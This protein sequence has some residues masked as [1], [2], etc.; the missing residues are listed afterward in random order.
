MLGVMWKIELNTE[1]ATSK[2]FIPTDLKAK[3]KIT[4]GSAYHMAVKYVYNKLSFKHWDYIPENGD[5]EQ[6]NT[7]RIIFYKK[8]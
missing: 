6:N 1:T 2:F 7:E 4:A 3:K 8:N 5:L